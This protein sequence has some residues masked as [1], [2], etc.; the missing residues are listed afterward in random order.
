ME[1]EFD[2][3]TK[4]MGQKVGQYHDAL[5]TIFTILLTFLGKSCNVHMLH[6]SFVYCAIWSQGVILNSGRSYATFGTTIPVFRAN[7]GCLLGTKWQK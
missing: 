6:A 4:N 5:C 3:T 1:A 2:K 7:S